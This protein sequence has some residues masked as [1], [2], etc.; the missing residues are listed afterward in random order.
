MSNAGPSEK[1]RVGADP[2]D[3]FAAERTLLAWVRTGLAMMGFGFVVARFGLFLRELAATG[4]QHESGHVG[5]SLWFGTGLVVLGV[6]VTFGSAV[7]HQRTVGRL[8]RG[9]PLVFA[10]ISLGVIVAWTLAL[11]GLAMASY[12]AI[13]LRV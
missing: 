5:L 1:A 9:E 13:G 11:L 4:L 2:R 3:Y 12:L 6:V 10:K 8:A 7:M